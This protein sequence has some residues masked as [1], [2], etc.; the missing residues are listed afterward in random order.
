MPW[1]DNDP[2]MKYRHAL[3]AALLSVFVS[4]WI[5]ALI[6]GSLPLAY[7]GRAWTYTGLL[8]WIIV[9]GVVVFRLTAGGEKRALTP[10]RLLRWVVSLWIWP[11]FLLRRR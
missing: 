11:V 2:L 8:L 3:V 9:G 5:A 6:A 1:N 4:L 10:A 7:A